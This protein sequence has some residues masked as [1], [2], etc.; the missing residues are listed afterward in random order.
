MITCYFD[1]WTYHIFE[2]KATSYFIC[3]YINIIKSI[4]RSF[5]SGFGPYGRDLHGLIQLQFLPTAGWCV[6]WPALIYVMFY[7]AFHHLMILNKYNVSYS[8]LS[9]YI[10]KQLFYK[11]NNNSILLRFKTSADFIQISIITT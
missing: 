6:K 4:F 7:I 3:V 1:M 10:F 8:F 5:F 9:L 2:H 11:T